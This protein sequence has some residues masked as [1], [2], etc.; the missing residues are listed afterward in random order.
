MLRYWGIAA[1]TSG[2]CR[3]VRTDTPRSRRVTQAAHTGEDPSVV[4]PFEAH[5]GGDVHLVPAAPVLEHFSDH[6]L[7]LSA[8]LGVCCVEVLDAHVQ[9]LADEVRAVGV[10]DAKAHEWDRELGFAE[11]GPACRCWAVD[12][13]G[14]YI[15][16]GRREGREGG[17]AVD[18]GLFPSAPGFPCCLHG[19]DG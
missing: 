19:N 8:Q 9:A 7:A 4:V 5:F 15:V 6:L 11:D 16:M 13:E 3:A 1:G 14:D 17:D 10:H 12:L 18:C 2:S